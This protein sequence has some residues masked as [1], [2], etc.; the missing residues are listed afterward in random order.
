MLTKTRF[1]TSFKSLRSKPNKKNP[2]HN[3]ADIVRLKTCAKVQQNT[4]NSNLVGAHHNLQFIRKK[5]WF[6]GNRRS[7]SLLL[8]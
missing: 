5:A 8:Y 7:F 1:L 2:V 6:L 4:F 3:F